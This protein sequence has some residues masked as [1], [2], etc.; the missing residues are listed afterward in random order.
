MPS[1]CFISSSNEPRRVLFWNLVGSGPAGGEGGRCPARLQWLTTAERVLACLGLGCTEENSPRG[2]NLALV[3]I[4]T[5]HPL[6]HPRSTEFPSGVLWGKTRLVQQSGPQLPSAPAPLAACCTNAPVIK[7]SSEIAACCA[8][9]LFNVSTSGGR[10]RRRPDGGRGDGSCGP[11]SAMTLFSFF[12][13]ESTVVTRHIDLDF[14]RPAPSRS[15][16]HQG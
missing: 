15:Q 12:K 6:M 1:V 9:L 13:R 4:R 7:K 16:S 3:P 2:A 10:W 8:A 5:K 11:L 14:C